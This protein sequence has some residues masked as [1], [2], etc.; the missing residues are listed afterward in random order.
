MTKEQTAQSYL[1]SHTVMHQCGIFCIL[2]GYLAARDLLKVRRC[3]S[4][5]KGQCG[6]E[7]AISPGEIH[8]GPGRWF[9]LQMICSLLCLTCTTHSPSLCARCICAGRPLVLPLSP[10]GWLQIYG[11][12]MAIMAGPCYIVLWSTFERMHWWN[13]CSAIVGPH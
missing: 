8:I 11:Q 7:P 10:A 5:P 6:P 1:N 9:K 12:Y 2:W 13:K 3:L 4:A